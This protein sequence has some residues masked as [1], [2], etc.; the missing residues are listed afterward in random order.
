MQDGGRKRY[1]IANVIAL[2]R[3]LPIETN[4]DLVMRVVGKTLE[5]N[6][7]KIGDLLD[8]AN[9]CAAGLEQ[10]IAKE[11]AAVIK[12][13]Q[14][15]ASHNALIAEVSRQLDDVREARHRLAVAISVAPAA[16]SSASEVGRESQRATV[17]AVEDSDIESIPSPEPIGKAPVRPR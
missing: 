7:V 9:A 14:Q 12:L 13:E 8:D 16:P 15:I 17:M 4:P 10:T 1:G 11:R 6:N 3:E 2:M 5:S